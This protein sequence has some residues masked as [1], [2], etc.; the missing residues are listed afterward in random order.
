MRLLSIVTLT[1]IFYLSVNHFSYALSI[2]KDL[3]PAFERGDK[4]LAVQVT[5]ALADQNDAQAQLILS[6]LY[7]KGYGDIP[8]DPR[9]KLYWLNRAIK[10]GS[11]D[12]MWTLGN[13]YENG[14][15][16]PISSSKAMELYNQS[17]ALGHSLAMTTLGTAYREGKLIQKND[18]IARYWYTRALG[19]SDKSAHFSA[20]LGLKILALEAQ[21]N[22][23]PSLPAR[24]PSGTNCITIGNMVDCVNF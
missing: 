24:R 6:S 17:A 18:S 20:K 11:A 15:G 14:D 4:K 13:D 19:T 22:T 3:R 23:A 7:R 5:S 1:T 10:S 16:V 2:E 9:Q 8:I 12:A 21:E